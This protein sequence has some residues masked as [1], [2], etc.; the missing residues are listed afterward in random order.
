MPTPSLCWIAIW[1]YEIG[2][3]QLF[4]SEESVWGSFLDRALFLVHVVS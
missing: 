2:P 1:R 4:L 3:D